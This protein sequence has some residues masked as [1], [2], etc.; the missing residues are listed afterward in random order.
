MGQPLEYSLTVSYRI[1]HATIIQNNNCT[2]EQS[3]RKCS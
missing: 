3:A 2:F 1:K